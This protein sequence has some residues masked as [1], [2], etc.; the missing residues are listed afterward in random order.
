MK[1]NIDGH[2]SYHVFACKHVAFGISVP[3]LPEPVC[4]ASKSS[5]LGPRAHADFL[6]HAHHV[7]CQGNQVRAGLGLRKFIV[8]TWVQSMHVFPKPKDRAAAFALSSGK[9]S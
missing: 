2:S 6:K 7:D 3:M 9:F 4:I 1:M 5:Q 8:N